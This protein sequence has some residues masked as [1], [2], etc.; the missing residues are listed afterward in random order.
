MQSRDRDRVLPP[1]Q[2]QRGGVF[3]SRLNR[4]IFAKEHL[5]A[6]MNRTLPAASHYLTLN[7]RKR[8]ANSPTQLAQKQLLSRSLGAR[9]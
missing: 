6:G 7:R 2:P 8:D 1:D 3:S 9:S 4:H 5:P